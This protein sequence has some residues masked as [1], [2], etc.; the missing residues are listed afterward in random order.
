MYNTYWLQIPKHSAVTL[1]AVNCLLGPNYEDT[2]EVAFPS[3]F[4]ARGWGWNHGGA[5]VTLE[6]HWTQYAWTGTAAWLSQANHIFKSLKIT[7]NYEKYAISESLQCQIK[8]TRSADIVP[9]GYLFL[10]PFDEF[11]SDAPYRYKHPDCPAYWS[12][13]LS[14]AQRL[15]TEDAENLGFPSIELTMSMYFKAWDARV[16]K[17]L[18]QFHEGKGF[19]PYSQDVA[20]HLGE[21]LYRLSERLEASFAYVHEIES[22][23]EL[24]SESEDRG[25]STSDEISAASVIPTKFI[26]PDASWGE[27]MQ[28]SN[29]DSSLPVRDVTDDPSEIY[30]ETFTVVPSVGE[31][32]YP[33][34]S[35]HPPS[36]FDTLF[37]SHWGGDA[38][39]NGATPS[40]RA[41]RPDSPEHNIASGSGA[42]T[43]RKRDAE[44]Q[45]SDLPQK[46]T[47][48]DVDFFLAGV[49]PPPASKPSD[50]LAHPDI[51][52]SEFDTLFGSH[53]GF[54]PDIG[55]AG[56]RPQFPKSSH[57]LSSGTSFNHLLNP[58]GKHDAQEQLSEQ[59]EQKFRLD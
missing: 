16:Y 6:N 29:V 5:G 41:A 12:L 25:L 47:R 4:Q 21:P 26:A 22:E 49:M 54:N 58:S 39:I 3:D 31:N 50:V 18:R 53:W 57:S 23:E 40:A 45:I 17:G 15:T 36:E 59:R 9:A 51:T 10:C 14:G 24:D 20:L 32:S 43:A 1:G 35:T 37:G 7:S 2:V 44:E 56:T 13:D 52:S 27:T 30:L 28:R 48:L 8:L 42:P 11:K 34:L 38:D 46:K 19:D 33:T 55:N